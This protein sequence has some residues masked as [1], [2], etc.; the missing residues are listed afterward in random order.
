MSL[1]RKFTSK[2]FYPLTHYGRWILLVDLTIIK[3][4][5]LIKS[6]FKLP[7]APSGKFCKGQGMTL[8]ALSLNC[9]SYIL[10]VYNCSLF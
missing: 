10:Q 5:V 1:R 3:K 8:N 2:R 9:P 7:E 6:S 4:L